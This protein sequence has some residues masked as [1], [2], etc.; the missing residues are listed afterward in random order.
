MWK[1][2]EKL[3]K[4][5]QSF[6]N[7]IIRIGTKMLYSLDFWQFHTESCFAQKM[8]NAKF[9]RILEPPSKSKHLTDQS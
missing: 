4:K 3:S 7:R 5:F 2:Q 8:E 6:E 9:F 1:W